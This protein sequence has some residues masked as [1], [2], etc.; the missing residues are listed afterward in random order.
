MVSS[1]SAPPRI[2]APLLRMWR[3]STPG[4]HIEWF[5]L[6]RRITVIFF[7]FRFR[8]N[9]RKGVD[10]SWRNSLARWHQPPLLLAS[11]LHY[12]SSRWKY[13]WLEL[14]VRSHRMEDIIFG[15]WGC[16]GVCVRAC[17]TRISCCH[18]GNTV[19]PSWPSWP[20][21]SSQWDWLVNVVAVAHQTCRRYEEENSSPGRLMVKWG[22]LLMADCTPGT[23]LL[24]LLL[25]VSLLYM[26]AWALAQCVSKDFYYH[27][28]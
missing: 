14:T 22:A 5:C 12:S 27:Y 17:E 28:F 20:S 23:V 13:V 9:Y 19:P 10:W 11:S 15:W 7:S 21:W 6:A 1:C 16:R 2:S 26:E 25:I 8:V 3:A 4:G 18:E 24:G